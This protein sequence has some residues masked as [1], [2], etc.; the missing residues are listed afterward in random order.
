M[1]T[2]TTKNDQH[3]GGKDD[4]GDK[5]MKTSPEKSGTPSKQAPS[6]GGSHSSTKKPSGH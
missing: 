5:G 3:H 1:A 2:H 6:S 4:K